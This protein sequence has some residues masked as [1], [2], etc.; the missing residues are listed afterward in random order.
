MHIA[1]KVIEVVASQRKGEENFMSCIR[2]ALQQHYGDKPVA[3][4]GT[5]CVEEGDCLFHVMVSCHSQLYQSQTLIEILYCTLFAAELQRNTDQQR[6]G[7]QQ[8]AQVLRDESA[9]HLLRLPHFL[10]SSNTLP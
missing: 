9:P 2:K 6:R 10:R 5:F 1:G 3:V 8:L 4:G 7:R